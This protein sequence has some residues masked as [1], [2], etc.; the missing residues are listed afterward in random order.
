MFTKQELQKY[1]R[2]LWWGLSTAR[3]GEYKP[4]DF[5][6]LRYDLD[7]LPL[8]EAM[9]D[10]LIEQGIVPVPR[11]GLTPN[12]EL[13]FYGKG[14]EEQITAIPAGDKEFM[15]NVSGV[16]SLIA[17]ASLTHLKEV[18]PSYIGKAAVARKFMRDIMEQR[19]ISGELGWTLCAWPTKAMADAAGLT[20]DEYAQQIKNACFLEDDD[21]AA[22]WRNVFD[23]AQQVKAW[24]NSL[25]V[26]TLHVESEHTDL[27]VNPGHDRQWLGVSG[28][29][30]PSFE[31]FLSPDW[32]DTRG[33]YFADQPSFRSG[34]L[35]RGVRLEFEKGRVVRS[36]AEEGADFVTKQLNMDKGASQL[37]EFSLTD[38]RFSRISA[39]MANTLFDENFG[40]EHGNCHVAVGASY[41]DTYAGDQRQLDATRK[42]ELGFNESA[43]HW[44]LVN[45]ENKTV[46]AKLKD[47]SSVVIYENGEFQ[48]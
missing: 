31:I 30:I 6:L 44:D 9:Y 2:T 47:G 14:S 8:A 40:G 32:R 12:M 7:A 46:T 38:R 16:I 37:G 11:A 18:D 4:G 5:V 17:P 41:A 23:E 42:K 33:V 24:L 43:L 1:A 21:P 35:V 27:I 36:D 26:E 10:L 25:D 20:L 15:A 13:S 29:N 34:N 45:T 22:T 19:E 28:H 39:F 48:Y 3:T